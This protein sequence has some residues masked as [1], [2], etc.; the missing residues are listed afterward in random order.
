MCQDEVEFFEGAAEQVALVRSFVETDW[1]GR[2]MP[3]C[4]DGTL[5]LITKRSA[6]AAQAHLENLIGLVNDPDATDKERSDAAAK[7]AKK[8]SASGTTERPAYLILRRR[9]RSPRQRQDSP[10]R[11]FLKKK[12]I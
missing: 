7:L 1:Q 10:I 12:S 11:M 8:R 2:E 5:R 4:A 9:R 6:D 3:T